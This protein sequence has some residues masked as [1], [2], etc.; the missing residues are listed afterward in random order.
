MGQEVH[1]QR[2][3][4]PHEKPQDTW[5]KIQNFRESF[6]AKLEKGDSLLS[7]YSLI[8]DVQ[9]VTLVISCFHE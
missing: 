9:K 2:R 8:G 4:L 6:G 3:G 1:G 5:I 7:K